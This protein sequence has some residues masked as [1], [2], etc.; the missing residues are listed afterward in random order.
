MTPGIK[1]DDI[2]KKKMFTLITGSVLLIIFLVN[3][4]KFENKLV[5]LPQKIINNE[6]TRQTRMTN[7]FWGRFLRTK[8]DQEN[9]PRDSSMSFRRSSPHA[10]ISVIYFM[11]KTLGR[12]RICSVCPFTWRCSFNQGQSITS[13][14]QL[15][16]ESTGF[17]KS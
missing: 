11:Q 4:L 15:P 6:M 13:Q 16:I 10:F 14:L 17:N 12:S 7:S 2:I 1:G 5:S 8:N 9:R 3:I